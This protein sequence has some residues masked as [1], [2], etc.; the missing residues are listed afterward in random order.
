[1]H[2]AVKQSAVQ[3]QQLYAQTAGTLLKKDRFGSR[4]S[5]RLA[6]QAW[7]EKS[8]DSLYHLQH[9]QYYGLVLAGRPVRALVDRAFC[10]IHDD[11][12]QQHQEVRWRR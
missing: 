1:M 11:P 6:A 7:L 12:L 5:A 2:R 10:D 8:N 9:H 3:K 4:A